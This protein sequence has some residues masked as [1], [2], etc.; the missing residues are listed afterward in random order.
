M[1]Y[2]GYDPNGDV[3]PQDNI[4]GLIRWQDIAV[5]AIVSLMV[6]PASLLLVCLFKKSKSRVSVISDLDVLSTRD[7]LCLIYVIIL[8]DWILLYY[9][10]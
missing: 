9:I 3:E 10:P 7:M 8:R 6:F 1:W 4:V 2:Q 5:G